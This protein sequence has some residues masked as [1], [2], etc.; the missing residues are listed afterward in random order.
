MIDGDKLVERLE[1]MEPAIIAHAK[2]K[3]ERIYIEQFRKSKKALLMGD[4][5]TQGI[6]TA[7]DRE[8]YAYAHLEYQKLLESLRAAIE[9]EEKCRWTLEH[10]KI[11][12]EMWRTIQANE[13]FRMDKV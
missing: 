2:A 4:A 6:K 9:V 3:S 10:L 1:N 5:G 12:F 13:R 7:V 11:E 8:Q